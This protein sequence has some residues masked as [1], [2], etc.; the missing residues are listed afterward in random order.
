MLLQRTAM[1]RTPKQLSEKSDTPRKLARSNP[2][3][4]ENLALDEVVSSMRKI[5]LSMKQFFSVSSPTSLNPATSEH[6]AAFTLHAIGRPSP[7]PQLKR[8]NPKP[9]WRTQSVC[10]SSNAAPKS[11]RY[12]SQ[13]RS[14]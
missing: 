8:S 13:L 14:T 1:Q 11:A 5:L 12:N 10:F 3:E 2:R 6:V 4:K 7:A 9:A